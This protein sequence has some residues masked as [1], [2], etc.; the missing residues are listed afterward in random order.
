MY[1]IYQQADSHDC[2]IGIGQLDTSHNLGKI[3]PLLEKACR[4]AGISR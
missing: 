1:K 2:R 3:Y 4:I